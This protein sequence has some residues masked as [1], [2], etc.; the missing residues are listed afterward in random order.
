MAS[1]KLTNKEISIPEYLWQKIEICIKRCEKDKPK[2]D[3]LINLDGE[4]GI[5]KTTLSALIGYVVSYYTKRPFSEKNMFFDVNEA[6]EFAKSTEK[7]IIIFDEPASDAL[8]AEWWKDTQKNLIKLLMMARK[9]RHFMIFNLTKFY[10]FAE[11]IVVDRARCLIHLYSRGSESQPRFIY[12]KRRYLERLYGD[13]R[14]KKKR[15]YFKY[16]KMSGKIRGTFPDVFDET[17]KYNILDVFNLEEYEKQKDK[18]IMNI[19]LK[20]GSERNLKK[21]VTSLTRELKK[22]KKERNRI[23]KNYVTL[24]NQ[25]GSLK[26]PINSKIELTEKLGVSKNALLSMA[27][28]RI[29]KEIKPINNT[30]NSPAL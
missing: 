15:N 2:W 1:V 12:I 20:V 4:E 6:V 16:G 27:K 30:D 7:Q 29:K 24:Q 28:K 22:I 23:E 25:V 17:K 11:Y 5:G 21:E 10:K 19:G 8:S 14:F 3:S 18:G 13:Y 26:P 9:K